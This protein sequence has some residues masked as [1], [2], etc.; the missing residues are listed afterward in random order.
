MLELSSRFATR[1]FLDGSAAVK[2]FKGLAENLL[3]RHSEAFAVI[4]FGSPAR[5]DYAPGSD[6]DLLVVLDSDE[7]RFIDRIPDYLREFLDAPAPPEVFPYTSQELERMRATGNQFV[8][9]ALAEG[10]V[11]AE[12]R[13]RS[14]LFA[15]CRS[16]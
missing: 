5:G 13:P 8:E 16:E 14:D 2:A 11:L 15:E 3:A 4:L 1:S 12:R 9:R 10:I 6:A 7:R